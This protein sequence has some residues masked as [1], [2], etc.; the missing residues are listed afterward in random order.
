[1][2]S[3]GQAKGFRGVQHFS[4]LGKICKILF[5]FSIM[6]FINHLERFVQRPK[7]NDFLPWVGIV[8]PLE[9]GQSK[10]AGGYDMSDARDM[11]PPETKPLTPANQNPW[12]LLMTLY[13]E[14][15]GE[16]IDR[17]LHEKNRTAWNAWAGQWMSEEARAAA[18]KSSGVTVEELAAWPRLRKEIEDLHQKNWNA[19]SSKDQTWPRLPDPQHVANFYE[20]V[21][22][23]EFVA[24]HL[25][26]PAETTFACAMFARTAAFNSATFSKQANFSAT[27]FNGTTWFLSTKFMDVSQFSTACFKSKTKFDS[28]YFVGACWFSACDFQENVWFGAT[29]FFERAQFNGV[30]F[31][32]GVGFR[33]TNFKGASWFDSTEFIGDT[34]VN[35]AEFSGLTY[36]VG[37]T[38]GTADVDQVISF[39]DCHFA[40]PTNFGNAR[41]LSRYPDFEGAVLHP[42]TTLTAKAGDA[43]GP[44]WPTSPADPVAAKDSCAKIRNNI[45]KQGFPEAEHFF[46]RKEMRFAGLAAANPFERL[47]YWLFG[48]LSDYGYSFV[49]PLAALALVFGFGFLAHWGYFLGGAARV[50]TGWTAFGISF[51]NLFP[52]FGIGRYFDPKALQ[53]L[54]T[55]LKAIGAMQTVSGAILLFL[56]ALGLRTRFR[57]R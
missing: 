33:A 8:A 11:T 7:G 23:R 13:G 55:A 22:E 40:K 54:P 21:F 10:K 4:T 38:F 19:R 28:A 36:F 35:R 57:M 31:K 50:E 53:M 3:A 37:A 48:L 18:A 34:W 46:Y 5:S 25:V 15:E 20:T 16:E 45:G 27:S 29:T 9:T 1:M 49:R 6:I 17:D 51:S 42:E 12:Y 41:F 43:D 39:N 32:R 24:D 47:A 14:Q 2:K 26:F 30:S 52:Y 44:F 56:F